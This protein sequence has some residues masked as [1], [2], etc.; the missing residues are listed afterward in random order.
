M[1]RPVSNWSEK[2]G[3]VPLFRDL[4]D[5][6]LIHYGPHESWG[7]LHKQTLGNKVTI[8]RGEIDLAPLPEDL[9]NI[10]QKFPTFRLAPLVARDVRSSLTSA[11]TLAAPHKIGV[12][13][14]QSI[15]FPKVSFNASIS[16]DDPKHQQIISDIE[17][18]WSG[19]SLIQ[20]TLELDYDMIEADCAY[21]VVLPSREVVTVLKSGLGDLPH[22]NPPLGGQV[23]G[24][25]QQ[26]RANWISSAAPVGAP[27]K[28]SQEVNSWVA[29]QVLK[30][31]FQAADPIVKFDSGE[32]LDG[33]SLRDPNTLVKQ[34]QWNLAVSQSKR[35][36]LK[37]FS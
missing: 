34:L 9:E 1:P 20:G 33:L 32:K 12:S 13:V 23:L 30:N 14:I 35:L 10:R 28:F 16:H 2:L 31:F 22:A 3:D 26:N 19:K 7:S 18:G 11:I 8:L 4:D 27:T 24:A 15:P 6:Q 5:S 17:T 29:D 21:R 37:I 25:V 36:T